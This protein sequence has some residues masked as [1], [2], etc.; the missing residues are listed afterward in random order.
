MKKCTDYS[1]SNGLDDD[2]G[3]DGGEDGSSHRRFQMIINL[4]SVCGDFDDCVLSS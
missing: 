1:Q 3:D 2:D 4:S